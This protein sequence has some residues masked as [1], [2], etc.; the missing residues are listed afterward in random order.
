LE[1]AAEKMGFS[2][3][4]LPTGAKV[5]LEVTV[6]HTRRTYDA[7]TFPRTSNGCW[8]GQVLCSFDVETAD[9]TALSLNVN[10]LGED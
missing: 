3:S 9:G 4:M 8:V 2:S 7:T 5:Y 1:Y 10:V 6:P